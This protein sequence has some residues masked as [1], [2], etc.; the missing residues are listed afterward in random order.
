M[1]SF[2][3]PPPPAVIKLQPVMNERVSP[4][5]YEFANFELAS[6]GTPLRHPDRPRARYRPFAAFRHFREL[7]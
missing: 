1:A 2:S 5:S 6:D 4:R 3:N 7:L